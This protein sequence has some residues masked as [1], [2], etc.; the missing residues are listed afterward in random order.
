MAA[1]WPE[2]DLA[3]LGG[4]DEYVV[5]TAWVN[6]IEDLHAHKP[7]QKGILGDDSVEGETVRKFVV[8]D[9]DLRL[10]KGNLY[11]IFGR[12]RTFEKLDE[13][14]IEISD[15]SHVDLLCETD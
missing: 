8:Y 3:E 12:D 1:S 7:Y 11:R 5:V 15:A 6:H 14:Q 2:R 9:S 10:E 13:I 4:R